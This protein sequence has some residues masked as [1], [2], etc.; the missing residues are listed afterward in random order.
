MAKSIQA[1]EK[2]KS[3]KRQVVITII[4]AVILFCTYTLKDVIKEKT[5]DVS[6]ALQRAEDL[7]RTEGGQSLL[8][9]H[10]LNFR[11]TDEFNQINQLEKNQL[12]TSDYSNVIRNDLLMAQQMQG[13]LN[14]DF[15]SV[16]RFLDK[17]PSGNGD[18]L[19][20]RDTLRPNIQKTNQQVSELLAKSPQGHDWVRF[21]QVKLAVVLAAAQEIPVAILGDAVLTRAKQI[22]ERADKIYAFADWGSYC[23]YILGIGLGLY[24]NLS[25]ATIL[26]GE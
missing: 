21:V 13:N 5:K 17:F 1:T 26:G 11:M 4:G 16:S 25:G 24:A 12:L 10:D 2:K 8:S 9:V 19:A 18:L 22:R 20:Q 3:R 14:T 7:F 23:F 6:D 15:D